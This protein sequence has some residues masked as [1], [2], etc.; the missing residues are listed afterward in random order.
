LKFFSILGVALL[1]VATS[2]C[3][4]KYQLEGKQYGSK[5]AFLKAT[6]EIT[7]GSVA[8]V[9]PLAAP[10]SM[11]TLAFSIP[12]YATMV[13]TNK[14]YH[15]KRHGSEPNAMVTEMI[16]QV[17]MSNYKMMKVYYDALVR[18]NIY[19][20]VQLVEAETATPNL[21]PSEGKDTLYH[22]E[23]GPGSA[24]WFYAS[25]KNGK[26]ILPVDRTPPTP[27][28]KVAA[29]VEAVQLQAIKD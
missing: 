29:F 25:I 27:A 7:S 12:S 16:D 11:R 10:V 23:T 19:R 24:N 4:I 8:S 9:T 1:A 20:S 5:E 17:T 22:Y 26:Q 21:E 2:G 18:R 28:G 3:A 14:E 13:R 15:L 6:D